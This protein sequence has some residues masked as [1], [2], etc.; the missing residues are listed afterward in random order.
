LWYNVFYLVVGVSLVKR[1]DGFFQDAFMKWAL[2]H[3]NDIDKY[4]LSD[5]EWSAKCFRAGYELALYHL[6]SMA[7]IVCLG[8][9]MMCRS[10]WAIHP[11]ILTKKNEP[12]RGCYRCVYSCGVC[13]TSNLEYDEP[14]DP[15]KY[16]GQVKKK[17]L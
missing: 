16:Y 2:N 5:V 6:S 14:Y 3:D 7:D 15:D 1:D 17:G 10:C 13:G 4:Q 8:H 11:H 9:S 12:E